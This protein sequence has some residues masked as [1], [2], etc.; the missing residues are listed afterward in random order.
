MRY[1]SAIA[2]AI[3][4]TL[5]GANYPFIKIAFAEMPPITMAF[6]RS[7]ISLPLLV[8]VAY[9]LNPDLR[10]LLKNWKAL[11]LLGAFGTVGYQ[12]LQNFGLTYATASESSVLLNSDP[13]YIAILA[14]LYLKEKLTARKIAG[15]VIAFAGVSTIVLR[16]SGGGFTFNSGAI[17]G[18]LLAIGGA[19]SWAVFSV[20]G[21][22]VLEK[23]SPYDMTA[24]SSLLG[25]ALLL[26]LAFGFESVTLPSTFNGWAILLFI[27]LGA[28]GVGYLLW[29]VGLK[30]V[31]AYEAGIALFFTPLIGIIASAVV[32]GETIDLMFG[33]GALLVIIGMYVTTK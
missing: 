1:Q 7:L 12:L 2:L 6:L 13:I 3:C 15:I 25:T 23:I 19:F 17:F 32:L 11:L 20:Y 21:K 27:G 5:W 18:D 22:K 31:S 24:Y 14:S 26:P 30:G 33:I 8:A 16:G 9:Y 4:I 10:T 28:S 29:F